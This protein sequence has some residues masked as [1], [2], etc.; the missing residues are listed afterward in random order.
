MRK[1]WLVQLLSYLAKGCVDISV[2]AGILDH[3]LCYL[4]SE[5]YD[6][7]V[8]CLTSYGFMHTL[9]AFEV[10]VII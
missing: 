3:G 10:Y 1:H 5:L 2:G 7:T 4:L 6:T 8:L 9:V